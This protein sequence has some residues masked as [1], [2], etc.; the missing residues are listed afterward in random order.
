MGLSPLLWRHKAF[1]SC[2]LSISVQQ[3]PWIPSASR[4]VICAN[5][6]VALFFCSVCWQSTFSSQLSRVRTSSISNPASAHSMVDLTDLRVTSVSATPPISLSSLFSRGM[7]LT[8]D[9]WGHTVSVGAWTLQR[10]RTLVSWMQLL[11][12]FHP[13]HTWDLS[14]CPRYLMIWNRHQTFTDEYKE[15]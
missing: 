2:P 14:V 15:I 3:S 10:V 4:T 8:Q 1:W 5:G 11:R 12:L 7:M 13:L 6:G 9:P